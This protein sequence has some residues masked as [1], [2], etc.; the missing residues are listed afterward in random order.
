MVLNLKAQ[1]FAISSVHL[2]QTKM[3]N[4]K[5]L[6][7]PSLV[8]K[9]FSSLL[10]RNKVSTFNIPTINCLNIFVFCFI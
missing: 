7:I 8:L 5:V 1:N 6:A 3:K 9:L 2:A 10:T 4:A